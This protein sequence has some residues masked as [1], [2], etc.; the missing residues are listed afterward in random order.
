MGFS[1]IAAG[2]LIGI[3]LYFT[4]FNRRRWPVTYIGW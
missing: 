4:L 1:D 2:D 3:V